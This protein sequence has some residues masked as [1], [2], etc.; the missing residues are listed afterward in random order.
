MENNINTKALQRR[1]RQHIKAKEHEFFAIVQPGFE[2]VA[3]NELI[4]RQ[5]GKNHKITE[6]GIGFTADLLSCYRCCLITRS[7]SRLLMRLRSFRAENFHRFHKHIQAIPWELYIADGSHIAFA[8]TARKSRLYHTKRLE[9]ESFDAVAKR[10]ASYGY[11]VSGAAAKSQ[12]IFIRFERD[13]CTVSLDASG[14]LLYRRGEKKFTTDAPLRETLAAMILLE[15]KLTD[16]DVLVD[17]MCGSGTFS[18]EA[19]GIAD[20]SPPGFKRDFNFEHWPAFSEAAFNHLK[21]EITSTSALKAKDLI[22]LA[23]D[24]DSR[25]VNAAEKNFSAAGS[26]IKISAPLKKDFLTDSIVLPPDKKC[27]LV[28]NPPY[29][30]RLNAADDIR[31][32]YKKIGNR[33]KEAYS[34]CGYAI[35]APGL[36]AEKALGLYYDRKIAFMNGGIRVAVLFKDTR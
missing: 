26:G 7:P 33:I 4:E 9:Q 10:M 32:L 18:I 12:T 20:C 5:I 14:G 21:K 29:G 3:L 13:I 15:A 1:V 35:I 27:L 36:E 8:I 30:G 25:A 31:T 22:I 28:L 6:G 17:P 2:H 19:A 16:Y 24:I 11:L 23:S 34:A